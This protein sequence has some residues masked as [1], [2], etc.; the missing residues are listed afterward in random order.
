MNL[1]KII[2]NDISYDVPNVNIHKDIIITLDFSNDMIVGTTDSFGIPISFRY[3]GINLL[4]VY[5][6]DVLTMTYHQD[7]VDAI[8]SVQSIT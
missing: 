8:S 2:K 6:D 1:I 4:S 7:I 3:N 5:N